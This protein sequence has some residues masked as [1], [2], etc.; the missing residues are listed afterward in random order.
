M[1]SKL[2]DIDKRVSPGPSNYDIPSKVVEKVGK[3]FG[4]KIL[5]MKETTH[6]PGPG[7]YAKTGVAEIDKFEY[8]M[9]AKI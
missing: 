1:G 4:L 3:T 2:V 8:S 5:S 9:G 7:A 6:V